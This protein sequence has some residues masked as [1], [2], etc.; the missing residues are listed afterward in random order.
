MGKKESTKD[1]IR[2]RAEEQFSKELALLSKQDND[3]RPHN[4]KLSPRAVVDYIMGTTCGKEII[5]PKYIGERRLIEVAVATLATD[6]AL[7]LTGIPG[8]AKTWVSE[9]LAAAISGDSSLL[10]Q[11]TAG[12]QEESLRY[13]WNYAILIAKGPGK[14]AL[15]ESPVLSAM[16]Q[17]KI[18][19]IEELSRIPAD[20]QDALITLLS[21]KAIPVPELNSILQA[22]RGFNLIATANDR[23][24]GV[25]DM[26]SALRRRFNTVIMP[27]P[28]DIEQEVQIVQYRVDRLV[29]SLDLPAADGNL[30]RIRQLVQ[31]FRELRD[32]ITQDGKVKVKVPSSTL[33]PAEAISVMANAQTLSSFFGNANVSDRDIAASITGAVIKDKE[34][35]IPA[36][37]EY[38]EKV[39]KN[40]KEW[41]ELYKACHDEMLTIG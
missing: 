33:S 9:H 6:R 1:I 40:R 22:K 35:D 21:E 14:D 7:L 27:L 41:K 34:K 18:V 15:V 5:E 23:D 12:L 36:W 3:R 19:R 31:I 20:V 28:K 30:D 39:M 24:K 17:G 37:S 29:E 25:H 10:V 32:G 11:G 4:W 8:T 38:L 26:S 16:E 13:G 2:L